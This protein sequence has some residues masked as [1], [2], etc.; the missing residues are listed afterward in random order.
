MNINGLNKFFIA[1]RVQDI[2]IKKTNT[3]RE[4]NE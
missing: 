4:K 1:M 3:K 2:T